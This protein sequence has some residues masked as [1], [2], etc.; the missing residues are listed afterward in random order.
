MIS[1]LFYLAPGTGFL[2]GTVVGGRYSDMTVRKWIAKRGERIPQDRLRS[3]MIAFFFV[4]PSAALLWGW[5]LQCGSCSTEKAGLALPIV[6]SFFI[7]FGL[8]VAFAS[9]NTYCAGQ[10]ICE[11]LHERELI[12]DA[13]IEAMPKKRREVIGGKYLL[14]YTFSACSTAGAVPL[15][16]AIGV[17][18]STT[19]GKGFPSL[20]PCSD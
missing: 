5:G 13:I 15:L 18:P 9:L 17:G 14:Q 10:F 7:A 19:I 16:E 4:I 6:T 12:A 11:L 2:V 1:G 20:H 8:L 3:G